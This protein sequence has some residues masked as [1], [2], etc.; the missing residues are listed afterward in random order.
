MG[1]ASKFRNSSPAAA[2]KLSRQPP[3]HRFAGPCIITS[4]VPQSRDYGLAAE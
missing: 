4:F 3:Q 1:F 2:G